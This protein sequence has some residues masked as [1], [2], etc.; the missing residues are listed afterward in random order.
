MLSKYL[1]IYSFYRIS[2]CVIFLI[3]YLTTRLKLFLIYVQHEV[4][5]YYSLNEPS[6]ILRSKQHTIKTSF[7][8]KYKWMAEK[9]VTTIR[10]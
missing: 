4:H 8:L 3:Q 1:C 10:T 5:Y 9:I 6:Y 2:I 7:N